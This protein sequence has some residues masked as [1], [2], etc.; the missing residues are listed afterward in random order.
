[1][2]NETEWKTMLYSKWSGGEQRKTSWHKNP[3]VFFK[4]IK[5]DEL[6]LSTHRMACR[7]V[8]SDSNLTASETQYLF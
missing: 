3:I 7:N 6:Y 5:P 8:R 1:M 2:M 4:L